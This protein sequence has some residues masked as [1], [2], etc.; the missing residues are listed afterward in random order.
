[1]PESYRHSIGVLDPN[2]NL[3]MHL[4]KY[5]NFDSGN[6]AK[7]RIPVGGDDIAMT[8]VRFVSGTDNYLVFEDWGERLV[9]LRLDYHEEA[10]AP[11]SGM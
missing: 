3:I 11:I 9:V 7:S 1:V 8:M 4:G 2:G 5:G 10:V 6:G